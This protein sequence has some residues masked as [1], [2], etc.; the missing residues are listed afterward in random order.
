MAAGPLLAYSLT[1]DPLLVGLA[2]F[3][4]SVPK[5]LASLTSGAIVD[6]LDRKWVMRVAN[7]ARAAALA[8]LGAAVLLDAA[9]L[10]MLYAALFVVGLS[11]TFLGHSRATCKRVL[12]RSYICNIKAGAHSGLCGD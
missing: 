7:C 12:L 11:E 4:Q 10:P 3:F 6:R 9:P 8:A 2:S 1:K 5:F